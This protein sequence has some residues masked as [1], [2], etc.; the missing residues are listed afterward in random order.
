[1]KRR[2]QVLTF[3]KMA[4]SFSF[5]FVMGILYFVYVPAN[6]GPD[7]LW[8]ARASWY[9]WEHPE[10]AFNKSQITTYRFPGSLTMPG[11]KVGGL[12][13]YPC[14][15]TQAEVSIVPSSCQKLSPDSVTKE[16]SF[17]RVFRSLPFY[18]AVGGGM[19]LNYFKNVYMSGKLTALLCNFLLLIFST[20]F[21][22]KSGIGFYRVGTLLAFTLLPSYFFLVGGLSPIAWEITSA[23]FF[24]CSLLYFS[25]LGDRV[26]FPKLI[27]VFLISLNLSLARPLGAVWG[28]AILFIFMKLFS[29]IR[30]YWGTAVSAF[31]LG[32]MAQLQID[33]SSWR[34]S[35]GTSYK[36]KASL[37][38]YIEE[39]IRIVINSGDWLRQAY[40]LWGLG[41]APTIPLIFVLVY[42]LIHARLILSISHRANRRLI[43][44]SLLGCCWVL[45][46]LIALIF[47]SKWPMW[48]SGRY[49]LPIFSAIMLILI[50][51]TP[52]R[53]TN[54]FALPLTILHSVFFAFIFFRYKTGLYS[55]NTP[56]M[57]NGLSISKS[58]IF[59]FF[60]LLFLA[61]LSTGMSA[62]TKEITK[63]G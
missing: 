10:T 24:L 4:V 26:S 27:L 18:F 50:L 22:V 5:P 16:V 2:F 52:S 63:G 40:G 6:A 30:P 46:V 11:E 37:A 33:N 20:Y 43:T 17:D 59:V 55:N 53:I 38:F 45:P 3:L 61:F 57:V 13:P 56:V 58:E 29:L 1:M 47:S 36:V 28:I 54:L 15:Y 42:L 12:L 51:H 44:L 21:I 14:Y 23:I 39:F 31:L 8:S 60:T 41:T 62:R 49:Q 32:V 25:S 7:E 48:W 9:L 34:F 19:H 35:D